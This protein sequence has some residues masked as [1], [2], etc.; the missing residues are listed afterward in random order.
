MK[1]YV[2]TYNDMYPYEGFYT[3][4]V[5]CYKSEEEANKQA[6]ELAR[7]RIINPGSWYE[8][9]EYELI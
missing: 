2:I 9:V 8:V 4:I 1:I 6:A 7:C 5:G 3:R